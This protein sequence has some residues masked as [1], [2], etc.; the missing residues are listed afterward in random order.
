LDAKLDDEGRAA[1]ATAMRGALAGLRREARGASG[2][3]ADAAG[4]PRGATAV[5]LVDAFARTLFD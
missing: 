1:V 5:A 3:L 2:A 4:L